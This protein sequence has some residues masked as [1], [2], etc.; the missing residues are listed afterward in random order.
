MNPVVKFGHLRRQGLCLLQLLEAL[1]DGIQDVRPL[2]SEPQQLFTEI[3]GCSRDLGLKVDQ[4]QHEAT[5]GKT[6]GIFGGQ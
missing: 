4:K 5:M 6:K 1:V 3:G 2:Q